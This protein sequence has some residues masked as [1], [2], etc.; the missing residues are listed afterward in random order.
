M[1]ELLLPPYPYDALEPIISRATV[2]QHAALHQRYWDRAYGAL[3]DELEDEDLLHLIER[4]P[5]S[6][7]RHEL[8]QVFNH[9]LYWRSLR[10]PGP[11]QQ[12]LDQTG[13]LQL[14]MRGERLFGS[15]Y[16]WVVRTR[17]AAD[18]RFLASRNADIPLVGLEL[19]LAIDLWEHSYYL[20]YFGDRRG[21]LKDV[22]D[23]LIDWDQ[24]LET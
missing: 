23:Y 11:V 20:D 19:L 18:T 22:V 2:E 6:A 13:R 5:E 17:G 7:L 4:T 8:C 12:R 3:G 10:P 16:L 15:G 24:V 21:Y 1:A 9:N 14:V